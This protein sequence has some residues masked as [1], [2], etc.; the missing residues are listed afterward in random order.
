MT[1]SPSP[2]PH[3]PRPTPHTD[4]LL[5]VAKRPAPGHTKTRLTPPLTPEQ[6]AALYECFLRDTLDLMRRVAGV[7]PAIAYLPAEERDYFA[8]L[9]PGFELVVQEGES[10]GERL[11]NA[12]TGYLEAGYARVVIMNSDGPTLPASS[13]AA[14][15]DGLRNG[16]DVVLGPSDD[17]GYYLI[18]LRQPAPRLLREVRMSTPDVL[19]DTLRIAAEE[20]L[21]VELLPPWYDVDDE[22]SL[23][24][25]REELATSPSVVALHTRAFL[26]RWQ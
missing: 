3:A 26:D 20:K 7:Q 15:F 6:A 9:A 5:V 12:L 14:A 2:T 4:A 13:L 11:D 16:A 19:T 25:L 24:R 10:L 23:A 21:K 1:Q 8:A 17:G 18:G 22:A